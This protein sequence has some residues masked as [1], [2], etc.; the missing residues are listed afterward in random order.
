MSLSGMEGTDK[1]PFCL[2]PDPST[3]S[4][5]SAPATHLRVLCHV[6]VN[7]CVWHLPQ[8]R[9]VGPMK[10]R[11]SKGVG[12][13]GEE[14]VMGY[15][16]PRV[17]PEMRECWGEGCGQCGPHPSPAAIGGPRGVTHS[18][19]RTTTS[20]REKTTATARPRSRFSRMV[21]TKVTSQMS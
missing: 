9:I 11:L 10:E 21:A 18:W 1:G 2:R 16:E 14:A 15:R 4:S 17:T 19:V 5:W 8:D 20:N 12:A 13:L 3:P 7:I 6:S